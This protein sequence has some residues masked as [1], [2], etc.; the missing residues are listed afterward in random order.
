MSYLV[1]WHGIRRV[2]TLSYQ[3]EA[4]VSDIDLGISSTSLSKSFHLLRTLA[5]R[6]YRHCRPGYMD[7]TGQFLCFWT[8]W[9]DRVIGLVAERTLPRL[10]W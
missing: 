4:M 1:R 8:R 6:R 2:I 5:L 9:R 10:E 7:E 3:R